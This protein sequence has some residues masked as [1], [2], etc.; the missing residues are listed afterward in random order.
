MMDFLSQFRP[1]LLLALSLATACSSVETKKQLL[2]SSLSSGDFAT[3]YLYRAHDSP[4]GAVGIDIKDNGLEIGTL[5]DGT[6]FV[7][8]AHPGDHLFIAT[9]DTTSA[10]SLR[11]QPG[12]TYYVEARVVRSQDLF[13]PSLTVV[14]D[15][16]GQAAIQNLDRLRYHE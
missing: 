1:L 9:T 11:L 10:Q 12:A 4:G 15:L 2:S 8:H 5:R 13:Q 3:V 16:Q 7:Y 14:F 6:Y